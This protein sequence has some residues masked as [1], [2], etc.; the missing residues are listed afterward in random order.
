M[1][2][3]LY[4]VHKGDTHNHAYVLCIL[5]LLRINQVNN[6]LFQRA[7]IN[8]W[9]MIPTMVVTVPGAA[10]SSNTEI[11]CGGYLNQVNG[12]TAPGTV[13]GKLILGLGFVN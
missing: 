5:T 2:N 6:C 8:A 11:F 12:Q 4:P 10:I 1:Y 13:V 9:V 7:C 3:Q